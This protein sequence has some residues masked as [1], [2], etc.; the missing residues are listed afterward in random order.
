MSDNACQWMSER[1]K[2]AK[3]ANLATFSRGR[4]GKQGSRSLNSTILSVVFQ[5]LL[6]RLHLRPSVHRPMLLRCVGPQQVARI[7]LVASGEKTEER[8]KSPQRPHG[9]G[10]VTLR[11]RLCWCVGGRP[12]REPLA[13]RTD[14][15]ART[16]WPETRHLAPPRPS[17]QL[18]LCRA[19][20]GAA[21]EVVAVGGG[22]V[23]L[24]LVGRE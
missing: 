13:A 8:S 15:A 6:V 21:E 22:L 12:G 18:S 14:R 19:I 7:T 4:A 20:S 9:A 17:C 23:V 24:H 11:P 5:V 10:E 1:V 2:V 16:R 3:V